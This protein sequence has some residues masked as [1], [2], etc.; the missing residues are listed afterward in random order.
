MFLA[1]AGDTSSLGRELGPF[2]LD[3]NQVP[4]RRERATGRE[5]PPCSPGES[6]CPG[7]GVS[8][9]LLAR[10]H[11]PVHREVARCR[12]MSPCSKRDSSLLGRA[13]G[14]DRS[15]L[16]VAMDRPYGGDHGHVRESKSPVIPVHWWR[17]LRRSGDVLGQDIT[18]PQAER[19]GYHSQTL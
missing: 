7:R 1:P 3:R 13:T 19:A 18:G 4:A 5:M 17:G 6:S 16:P 9:W 8:R 15:L 11:F 10:R 2:R 14:Q 12:E